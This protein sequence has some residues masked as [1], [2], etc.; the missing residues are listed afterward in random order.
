MD[1]PDARDI[2]GRD[3]SSAPEALYPAR[4]AANASITFRIRGVPLN[5]DSERLQ[6]FL[7]ERENWAGLTV[8]S[9]ARET[10][11]RS[12]TGTVTF[13]TSPPQLQELETGGSYRIQLPPGD[14]PSRKQYLVVDKDF[15]GIT[16]LYSPPTEDH[17]IDIVSI[18]G[19]GGHAFGSFKERGEDHMWL[20]DSLPFDLIWEDTGRP[21]ARSI[22]YGYE[23]T[24]AKSDNIQNL[25]DL[26][27][28]FHA[29]MRALGR[30]AIARPIILVAHSLGGL[31]VKQ[32]LVALSLSKSVGDKKL[33]QRVYG[34]AFFGV[35]HH[36]MDISSLIPMVGDSP[37]RFLLE[38]MN[39]INSQI[40]D[41][42]RRQFHTALGQEGDSEIVCFYE[43]LK[44]PTAK[45]DQNGDWKMTGPLSVLVTRASATHCRAWE[46]GPEHICAVARTHSNMVKFGPEDHEYDKVCEKLD[47]LARQALLACQN[48]DKPSNAEC[49][50]AI[51]NGRAALTQPDCFDTR[52]PLFLVPPQ[53]RKRFT[54]R[55]EVIQKLTQMLFAEDNCHRVAVHGL[56]GI[57]KTQV[58]LRVAFWTKEN[59]P[60]HSVLW[61]SADSNNSFEQA[62]HEIIK[63]AGFQPSN[64]ENPK[65]SV[66]T[67]LGSKDAGKW[68][69]IIDG[70]DDKAILGSKERPDSIY[71]YLPQSETGRILFTTRSRGVAFKVADADV[72]NLPE[73]TQ[74]EGIDLLEKSLVQ[75]GQ[76]ENQD[77]VSELLEELT[78]LPL[79]I[80]QVA[81]HLNK[82]EE[83]IEDYLHTYRKTDGDKIKLLSSS[84]RDRTGS[85]GSQNDVAT[86]W[87]RSFDHVCKTDP[88]AMEIL[89]FVA[90]IEPKAIPRSILPPLG[91]RQSIGHAI[92]TLSGVGFLTERG[93]KVFD[94]HSL[95][96]LMT[97][98]WAENHKGASMRKVVVHLSN[99]F[100]TEWENNRL[101]REWLPHALR[102]LREN[103]EAEKYKD[104]YFILGKEIGSCL[105]LDGRSGEAVKLLQRMGATQA[106]AEDPPK[107]LSL[108]QHLAR[109]YL[110][111]NQV[112]EAV[113]LLQVVVS[114]RSQALAEDHPDRLS[115]QHELAGAY[116]KNDQVEE[117]VE[118]LLMVVSI[119]SRTLAEDDP[120]RLISQHELAR[121]YL[122]NNQIEKAL[123]L[124]QTVVTIRTRA[125]AEGDPNRLSSERVLAKLYLVSGQIE[126]AVK[127]MEHVVTVQ[128][129]VLPENHP[130]RVS[131]QEWLEH[132]YSVRG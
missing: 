44:S 71:N 115:S 104:E 48:H 7:L 14:Q 120:D 119:E 15:Y 11:G 129:R 18:S 103:E 22:I 45:K 87:L 9:L 33:L 41:T 88:V 105:L 34:I 29:S 112:E 80:A 72:L 50:T 95:V 67:Y 58:A 79:A 118:L 51:L 54:G 25:E 83:S 47:E 43:T 90:Y 6:S 98:R 55:L 26:A 62:C 96:H 75:K 40:L 13:Q 116:L 30:G 2:R 127:L 1:Q 24:V 5:W 17:K 61:I 10:T 113:K 128:N 131:S 77:I 19:I 49:E 124:L 125:I 110:K 94:M 107:Q 60:E 8:R 123:K 31:I 12:G 92:R 76:L 91:S 70:A 56:G 21:M 117:A 73:M 59:M 111:N 3:A 86:T 23:S 63:A 82:N 130:N 89:S 66:K 36:G 38:S 109:A 106:L 37:N 39:N 122:H 126:E 20:R 132:M 42:Q 114:I 57:G 35:P 46:D 32:M 102:V 4:E 99:V 100:L 52:Q 97:R 78:C 74:Q 81:E 65:A 27:T 69:L 53:Q 108:R 93:N 64:N 121:A 85:R 28:S 68:L 84:Y 16:T 101:R